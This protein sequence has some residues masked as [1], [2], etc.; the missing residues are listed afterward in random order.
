MRD[1]E[2]ASNIFA[3]HGDVCIDVPLGSEIGK[4]APKRRVVVSGEAIEDFL[5]LTPEAAASLD[6]A[7][8][9]R[10]VCDN[11]E[12]ILR[13]AVELTASKVIVSDMRISA[14]PGT[15]LPDLI[16]I[17]AGEL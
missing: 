11:L 13:R 1:R 15:G 10:F 3:R 12:M 9:E 4:L 14:P 6:D 16:L 8:R 2:D 5:R 7:E 17:R